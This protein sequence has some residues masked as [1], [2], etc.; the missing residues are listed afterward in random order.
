MK[1]F[2]CPSCGR[3]L[4]FRLLPHV[5][6][7]N[8]ELG[9]SCLHCGA[10]LAYNEGPLGNLFLGTRLRSLFTILGG[11]ALSSGISLAAGKGAAWATL[12]VLCAVLIAAHFLSP[13]PAYK[14]LSLG[15]SSNSGAEPGNQDHQ[16]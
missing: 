12:A 6:E 7:S 4:R 14:I 15:R 9:F 11:M 13:R 2:D 5:P 16:K 1:R 10:V 8:R 3:S